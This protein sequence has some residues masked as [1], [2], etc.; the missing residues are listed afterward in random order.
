MPPAMAVASRRPTDR[1]RLLKTSL[2]C[3]TFGS[4]FRV[5]GRIM[6]RRSVPS[7]TENIRD[8][9]GM[10]ALPH[11]IEAGPLSVASGA[12]RAWQGDD[13]GGEYL[14]GGFFYWNGKN[15]VAQWRQ[16]AGVRANIV[17]LPERRPH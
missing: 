7:A 10:P 17:Q 13:L 9:S 11:Q 8:P 15:Y 2:L 5:W 1:Q 3:Q 6:R 12:P 16:P 4:L 14:S